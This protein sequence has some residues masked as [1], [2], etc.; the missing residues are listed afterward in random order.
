MNNKNYYAF[1]LQVLLFF[2]YPLLPGVLVVISCISSGKF[3][4]FSKMLDLSGAKYDYQGRSFAWQPISA[5]VPDTGPSGLDA[6]ISEEDVEPDRTAS[7]RPQRLFC[8]FDSSASFWL[9]CTGVNSIAC[10]SK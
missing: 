1:S 2:L 9:G 3:N 5:G 10:F 7:S 6:P 4:V 8:V